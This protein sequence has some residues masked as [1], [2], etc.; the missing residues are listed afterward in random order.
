VDDLRRTDFQPAAVVERLNRHGVRYVVIGGLAA[1]LH[2]SPS[3]TVDVDVCYARDPDNLRR[4]AAALLEAHAELRGAPPELPFTPD[5]ATL[6]KGDAF[7]LLT[8]DGPL[9]VMAT[10]A[11]TSGFD[12][13][14]ANADRVEAFGQE[15]LVAGI[16][17]LIRMK[18]AAGQPKDRAELEILGA[19]REEMERPPNG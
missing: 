12:D 16:D 11:G 4:L 10:P 5:A 6:A 13:L 9:D 14:A 8:D 17:D 2:G 15:F 7:T 3:V 1:A 18:R 19:L